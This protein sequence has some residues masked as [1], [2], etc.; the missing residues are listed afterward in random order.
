M[1]FCVFGFWSGLAGRRWWAERWWWRERLRLRVRLFSCTHPENRIKQEHIVKIK[2]NALTALFPFSNFYS[3]S[4][5]FWFLVPKPLSA[6]PSNF[7]IWDQTESRCCFL[8]LQPS[9]PC[10]WPFPIQ[11]HD[12]I[13]CLGLTKE[14]LYVTFFFPLFLLFLLLFSFCFI[15]FIYIFF[16]KGIK[17]NNNNNKKVNKIW[18]KSKLKKK[19]NL[20]TKIKI[21]IK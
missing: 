18:L 9:W 6:A 15:F 8:L 10:H 13:A 16:E 20:K 2:L 19:L 5:S 3:F 11:N 1:L 17:Q 4:P 14:R 7:E 12:S 21:K